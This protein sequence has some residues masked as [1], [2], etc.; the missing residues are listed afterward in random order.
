MVRINKGPKP[1]VLVEN[2]DKWT[3]ALLN[4]YASGA[5]VPEAIASAYNC[6]EVKN[7][8]RNEARRKCMYCESDIAHVAHE[9]IEHF[10]PKARKK[11]PELTFDWDNLGLACPV[12]NVNKSDDFDERCPH[13]N[14]YQEDPRDFFV[15]QGPMIFPKLG[16]TRA[17]LT[18][19]SVKMDRPELIEKR[20]EKL[21]GLQ[22]LM[23][24]YTAADS[25]LIK[26]IWKRRIKEEI[27]CDREYSFC[28]RAFVESQL[29]DAFLA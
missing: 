12:C 19:Q 11:Y 3:K 16:N 6:A 5:V 25:D 1:A 20:A 29:G 4:C 26:D 22:M 14:P 7:A 9:H 13:V 18:W 27:E 8:L 24:A 15:A 17:E 28:L 23:R 10:R 21:I 2:A